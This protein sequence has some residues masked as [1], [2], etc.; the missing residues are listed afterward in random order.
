MK[1]RETSDLKQNSQGWLICEGG[2]G[3]QMDQQVPYPRG[4]G[5]TSRER[6]NGKGESLKDLEEGSGEVGERKGKNSPHVE[7]VAQWERAEARSW[8]L[9]YSIHRLHSTRWLVPWLS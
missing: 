6:V 1:P 3:S 4:C 7:G 9:T 2:M 8:C 5:I